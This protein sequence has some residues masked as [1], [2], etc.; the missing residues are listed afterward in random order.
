MSRCTQ[1]PIFSQQ[2]PF[3]TYIFIVFLISF[4]NCLA[5]AAPKSS[6]K[7]VK[8]FSGLLSKKNQISYL[9]LGSDSEKFALKFNDSIT[10]LIIDRLVTGDY[11]SVQADT[12]DIENMSLK[13]ISINFIGL[14]A[15]LGSWI[16]D[17]NVCYEFTSFTSFIIYNTNSKGVCVLP[18]T[19]AGP[20]VSRKMSFVV[21]PDD[22]NW[23][24]LISNKTTQYAAELLLKNSKTVQLNLFDEENGDIISKV[25]L[26]R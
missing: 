10:Q 2:S 3:G 15:L 7:N 16:G 19:N 18:A 5:L 24:L 20:S 14:K 21:L 17:D 8:M 22:Q 26:R 4:V 13:I 6:E 11:L 1:N 9:S 25:V 12:S 23:F